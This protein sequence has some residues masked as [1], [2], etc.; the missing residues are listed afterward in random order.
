MH[1]QGRSFVSLDEV[2]AASQEALRDVAKNGF[3]K[4][5]ERWHRC[6]VTQGTTLKVD[7]HRCGEIFMFG[8]LLKTLIIVLQTA[9]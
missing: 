9:E 7:V 8:E 4:L 6:T 3:Q 2:K 5:Y 1:L